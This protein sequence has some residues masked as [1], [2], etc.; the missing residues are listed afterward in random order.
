MKSKMLIA[1]IPC[2]L[3]IA[4]GYSEKKNALSTQSPLNVVVSVYDI[5]I[6]TDAY[7]ILTNTHI[8]QLYYGIGQ[9]GGGKFY[10]LH[11]KTNS[12]KQ[13]PIAGNI[14]VLEQLPITGNA[15]QK[16]NRNK[17][18]KQLEAEFENGK[19][20]FITSVSRKLIVPK[21]HKFSNVKNALELARKIL[22]NP[23]YS[24]YAKKLLVISD[25]ENDLPPKQG[26]EEMEP[27]HF[28]SDVKVFLVRPSDRVNL[29]ELIPGSDYSIY[30]TIDDAINGMFHK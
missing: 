6:S 2:V 17:K 28:A 4:C 22:E 13:D 21:I 15:Y 25:L 12:S 7:A 20:S 1:V 29:S 3:I 9:N 14:S 24:N 30:T 26:I 8:E 23:M 16:A 27:V 10:G 19:D 18:N 11:I 5:T